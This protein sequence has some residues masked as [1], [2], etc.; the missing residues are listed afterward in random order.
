MKGILNIL[1]P[2]NMSSHDVV[3]VVR[4]K[5]NIQ[6]V[7]HTGTLDPMAVG[8]LP[9]CIGKATK[10]IE[11]LQNDTKVYRAEL[12]LG[13]STDTQDRWGSTISSNRV[14]VTKKDIIDTFNSFKGEQLQIPPMYSALKHRGKKLYELARDGIEVER[15]A[16]EVYIY[17]LNIINIVDNKILFDVKCSKGTYVRTICHDIGQSLNC[18]GH[19]SFLARLE[20]GIFKLENSITIEEL[21]SAHIDYIKK[22]YLFDT[23]YPLDF[24]SKIDVESSAMKS[25]LN[26]VPLKESFFKSYKKISNNELVRLYVEDKFMAL[27]IYHKRKDFSFIKVKKLFS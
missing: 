6:K 11:Y 17:Y 24:I 19:M 13:T 1:K 8:V 3:S 20:S 10:V 5:L 16:R 27:G 25:L 22:Y 4:R 9:I 18:G 23:D 2:P 14:E 15:K 26:G 21:N 12:T 7:G